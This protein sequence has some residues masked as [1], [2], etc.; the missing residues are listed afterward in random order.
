MDAESIPYE[1]SL[2]YLGQLISFHEPMD[3]EIQNP[4]RVAWASLSSC[5]HKLN[6]K[7]YPLPHRLR[8][9]SKL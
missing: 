8:L 1:G 5:K 6:S 2:K 4:A 9:V 3:T 7:Y